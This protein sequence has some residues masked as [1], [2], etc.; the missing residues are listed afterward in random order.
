MTDD[1]EWNNPVQKGVLRPM[2]VRAERQESIR[3]DVRRYRRI[4]QGADR[5]QLAQS[6]PSWARQQS[7]NGG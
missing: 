6:S 3:C 7:I 5:W 1:G 2:A 4:P